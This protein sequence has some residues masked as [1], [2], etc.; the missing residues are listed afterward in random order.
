MIRVSTVAVPEG[1]ARTTADA[2]L[3]VGE[4][5]FDYATALSYTSNLF[6]RPPGGHEPNGRRK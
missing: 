6:E 1:P 3:G 2:V 4:S 5:V